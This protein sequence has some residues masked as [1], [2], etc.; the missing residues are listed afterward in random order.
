MIKYFNENLT[1]NKI[2][3]IFENIDNMEGRVIPEISIRIP[4][5]IKWDVDIECSGKFHF[6]SRNLYIT[7]HERKKQKQLVYFNILL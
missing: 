2:A 5:P 1:T 4:V 3:I 7:F 6:V